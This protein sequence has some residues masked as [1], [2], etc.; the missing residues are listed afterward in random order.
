MGCADTSTVHNSKT[1]TLPDH[2][3]TMDTV[4]NAQRAM[5]TYVVDSRKWN[6]ALTKLRHH[7]AAMR[8]RDRA[9]IRK[10][11]KTLAGAFDVL[12]LESL[13]ITGMGAS[14]R[15]WAWAGIAA[16]RGLN[17]SIRAA[18]WGFTQDTLTAAFEARG[19]TVL[20]L[21]AMDSSRTCARCGHVDAKNRS[22]RRFKC[23][24]CTHTDN[25][26]VNAGNVLRARALRWLTLRADGLTKGEV[27]NTLWKEL[28]ATRKDCAGRGEARTKPARTTTGAQRHNGDAGAPSTTLAQAPPTPTGTQRSNDAGAEGRHEER[29]V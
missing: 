22:K 3:P 12:G 29:S 9:A 21:P 4:L 15:T 28:V 19:G 8:A 27:N 24:T 11:A 17:R 6:D 26:D 5:S 1:I 25:A 16:K 7:K 10:A 20:K 14:A 23:T 2:G 13:N 18:L